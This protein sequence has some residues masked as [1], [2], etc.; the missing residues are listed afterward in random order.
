LSKL[1][2]LNNAFGQI[3]KEKRQ[4]KKFT[5]SSLAEKSGLS[6]SYLSNLEVGSQDPSINTIFLL[7]KTLEIKPSVLVHMLEEND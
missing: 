5:Q 4:S 7:A 2:E 6:R 1:Y 3:L